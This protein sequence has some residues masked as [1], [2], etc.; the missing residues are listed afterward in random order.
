MDNRIVSKFSASEAIHLVY[1]TQATLA[2]ANLCL[3]K[4]VS[5]C[6]EVIQAFHTKDRAKDM[7][8]L[9]LI[10]DVLPTQRS[11]KIYWDLEIASLSL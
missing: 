5:N 2:T 11:L 6:A 4:I 8:D 9:N 7:R 1:N 10:H 3:H